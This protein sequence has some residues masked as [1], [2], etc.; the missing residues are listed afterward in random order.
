MTGNDFFS[1][2]HKSGPVIWCLHSVVV[3]RSTGIIMALR[4]TAPDRLC[5]C[6]VLASLTLLCNAERLLR[7]SRRTAG[8]CAW[9]DSISTDGARLELTA[10]AL[11][12]AKLKTSLAGNCKSGKLV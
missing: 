8:D 7:W 2:C 4:T 6:A 12:A 10:E 1:T 5:V 3:A 11:I 9:A